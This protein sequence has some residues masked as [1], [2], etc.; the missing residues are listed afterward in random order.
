MAIIRSKLDSNNPPKLTPKQQARLAAMTEEDIE[1]NAR[2]DPD[3]LPFTD[4]ELTRMRSARFVR[5]VREKIGLSQ[6]VFAKRFHINLGRLRDLEQ[7]RTAADSAL[8]AYLQV[9][10]HEQSAVERALAG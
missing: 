1:R 4:A 10:T 9:I 2:T 5:Q 8:I 6:A 3:N 7:G